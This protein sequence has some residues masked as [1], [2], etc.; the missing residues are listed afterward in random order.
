MT[1][2]QLSFYEIEHQDDLEPILDE[3]AK[4]G[5]KV[6]SYSINADMEIAHVTI[7]AKDMKA[8]KETFKHTGSVGWLV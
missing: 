8:F 2:T 1:T 7:E 5:A 4:A 3:I 6:V